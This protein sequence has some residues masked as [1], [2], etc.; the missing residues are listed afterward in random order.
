MRKRDSV[1][2]GVRDGVVVA[3]SDRLGYST[4]TESV[5]SAWDPT[6]GSGTSSAP[7]PVQ[8]ACPICGGSG[9]VSKPPGLAADINVWESSS[10]AGS[11]CNRCGGT[12]RL[13]TPAYF[14]YGDVAAPV[15]G[16]QV[17]GL[18]GKYRNQMLDV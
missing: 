13:G 14:G 11:T 4:P 6:F 9:V 15:L 1:S 18:V 2:G 17:S 10:N 12:G 5:V 3:G 16:Q 7:I 8:N